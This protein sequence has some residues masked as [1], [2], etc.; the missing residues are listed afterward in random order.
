M[1]LSAFTS[2]QGSEPWAWDYQGEPFAFLAQDIWPGYQS[3][4]PGYFAAYE[5][6]GLGRQ[7]LYFSARNA[8]EV[9]QLWAFDD[10]ARPSP[11]PSVTPS[12]SP[13]SSPS[14]SPSMSSTPTASI[15][16]S[17]SV[18]PSVT[19]TPSPSISASSS[20]STIPDVGP[21]DAG[22]RSVFM[23]VAVAGV[24]QGSASSDD[25]AAGTSLEALRRG[26]PLAIV[27]ATGLQQVRARPS[28]A[29]GSAWVDRLAV[30]GAKPDPQPG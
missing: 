26:V 25:N 9:T 30:A 6:S 14:S 29:D 1:Y 27:E 28:I 17:P 24:L 23:Q 21:G 18:T 11:T 16:S 22:T 20:P 10:Q 19:P 15:S 8:S 3:S 5:P 12:V 13:T 4:L 7:L 2:Q